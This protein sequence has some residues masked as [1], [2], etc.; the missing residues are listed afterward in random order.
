MLH[1]YR[2]PKMRHE[3]LI[4]TAVD[5][6]LSNHPD[7]YLAYS[8]LTGGNLRDR[9]IYDFCCLRDDRGKPY[10]HVVAS[11]TAT[12]PKD[13]LDR[14]MRSAYRVCGNIASKLLQSKTVVFSI[15]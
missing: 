6:F 2:I 9:M 5:Q 12:S 15:G 3:E 1:T 14:L 7:D 11:V 13:A 10:R 8:E 4:E